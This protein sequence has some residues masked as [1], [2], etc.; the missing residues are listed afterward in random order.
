MARK[1]HMKGESFKIRCCRAASGV[2][3]DE[4]LAQPGHS[5]DPYTCRHSP[6]ANQPTGSRIVD[7]HLSHVPQTVSSVFSAKWTSPSSRRR[8]LHRWKSLFV[9]LDWSVADYSNARIG[10]DRINRF[11]H[12]AFARW[13]TS[14]PWPAPSQPSHARHDDQVW[15]VVRGGR[16]KKIIGIVESDD[17]LY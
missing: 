12:R 8:K 15:V 10:A 6:E 11:I 14:P 3:I 1:Q 5:C 7:M 13:S 17:R 2:D 4:A 16:P 9:H